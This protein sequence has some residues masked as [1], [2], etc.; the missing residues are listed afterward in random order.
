MR[1]EGLCVC[2]APCVRDASHRT[3]A[4]HLQWCGA[5][6]VGGLDR[7]GE[8]VSGQAAGGRREGHELF[9]RV[10]DVALHQPRRRRQRDVLGRVALR[11]PATRELMV[12]RALENC[13]ELR[14]NCEG[15]AKELRTSCDDVRFAYSKARASRAKCDEPSRSCTVGRCAGCG[16]RHAPIK[17]IRNGGLASAAS[18]SSGG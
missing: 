5:A 18:A 17:S 12:I 16:S 8:R 7:F 14:R 3:G 13:V 11:V 9:H 6:V 1:A 15:T 2:E 4:E 10:A